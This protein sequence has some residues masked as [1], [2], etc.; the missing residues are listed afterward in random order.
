MVVENDIADGTTEPGSAGTLD[1]ARNAGA[2]IGIDVG[3]TDLKGSVYDSTGAELLRLQRPTPVGDGVPAVVTAIVDLVQ[4]LRSR[5]GPATP[6]RGVG[7]IFP[8]VVEA[9]AGMARYSV[10]IGWRDLPLRDLVSERVG[11]PVAI[12]HDVRAGG[13]AELTLGAARGAREALFVPIGT[14]IAGAVISG[15]AVV[16]GARQMAGEIGHIPVCPDGELCAC[17]QRGCTETYASASA[18]PRRYAAAA[19]AQQA[20][21]AAAAQQAPAAAAAQPLRAEDVLALA[22]AGDPLARTV[23]DEALTALGRALVTYTMLMDPSVI[24]IGGGMVRAG[25]ALL[26]PLAEAVQ[27]GLVWRDAPAIVAARFGSDAGRVGAAL[28]GWQAVRRNQEVSTDAGGS[29]RQR[30]AV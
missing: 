4:E 13:L 20:P 9:A 3:G 29:Y 23:F 22:A 30:H 21:A 2:V 26:D 5:T 25:S 18:L 12:D 27:R 6:V 24:V 7:L 8:G 11:L 1:A 16:T 17:G 15:G 19:A 14:G 10:N 28:V